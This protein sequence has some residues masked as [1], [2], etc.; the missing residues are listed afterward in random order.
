M[1]KTQLGKSGIEVSAVGFGGM[2]LPSVDESQAMAT[3]EKALELGITLFETGYG[4][5][6]GSSQK[7]IG[8]ATESV[9]DQVVLFNKASIGG[10]ESRSEIRSQMQRALSDERTDHFDC[11]S[12]WG[13]NNAEIFE[14]ARARGFFDELRA[15]RDEGLT[16]LIGIT[17]HAPAD[18]I[19]DF[20]SAEKLD[21]VTLKYNLL[22]RR[23]APAIEE[24]GR[25]GVGCV[26]MNPLAGGMVASPGG[27]LRK[28]FDEAGVPPAVLGLR[29]HT[30]NPGVSCPI[31]GMKSP[32]EVAENVAAGTKAP[33]TGD[34]KRLV[35]LVQ[36][37]L[38]NL[39]EDFCTGCG[40]CLPCPEGV[41]ISSIFT[42]WNMQRGYGADSYTKLEY[43]KIRE[44]RHWADYPGKSA[45]ECVECGECEPKCPNSIPIREALK[46]AHQDLM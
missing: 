43:K 14:D 31:P 19:I 34:E 20:T 40:Y 32:D 1:E 38:E 42:I 36:K 30:S 25:R 21:V 9:R 7:M 29:Y 8:R 10:I 26:V 16:K 28:A 44:Q 33:L 27:D 37:A 6:A 41:G 18:E 11:F 3:L 46:Q 13:V 4:Y 24:L 17:T 2:R 15:M 12:L 39:G 45:E 22:T 35:E 23:Q 5:G